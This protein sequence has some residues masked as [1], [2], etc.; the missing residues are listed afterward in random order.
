MHCALS[1]SGEN[2]RFNLRGSKNCSDFGTIHLRY[3]G[4]QK[5]MEA[6]ISSANFCFF[7]LGF[8]INKTS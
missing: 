2:A 7:L 1:F 3:Q 8:D 6:P 5:F 4:Q